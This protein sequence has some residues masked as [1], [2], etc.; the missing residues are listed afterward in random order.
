MGKHGYE[1]VADDGGAQANEQRKDMQGW[2][3][4]KRPIDLNTVAIILTFLIGGLAFVSDT[5]AS[6]AALRDKVVDLQTQILDLKTTMFQRID[7]VSD[8]VDSLIDGGER[9]K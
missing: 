1:S 5:R 7:K 3:N 8:R 9:R 6:N 2:V 4:F